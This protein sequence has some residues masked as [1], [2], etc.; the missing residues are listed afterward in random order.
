MALAAICQ[1]TSGPVWADNLATASDLVTQAAARGATFVALP[2]NFDL[3]ASAEAK[4]AFAEGTSASDRLFPL[5]DL[6]KRLRV[7]V[8]C[9][10]IAQK[11][12]GGKIHNTSVLLGPD[13][14]T[15]ATYRKVHLF[16]A[17]VGDGAPYRESELVAPGVETV[18]A[19]ADIGRIGM[20]IC[21]DL[22]FPE[23]Y[24]RLSTN[25]AEVL[26]VPSAFSEPTGRDHWEVLLRARAIE[27]FAYVIAP[28]QW[29]QHAGGR[30]TYGRSMIVDP[31]G[32]VMCCV[33]DGVGIG[34]AEIDLARLR[35][36]RA[37]LP[38]LTHRRL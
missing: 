11:A 3:M 27:N 33:P 28:A 6:A 18:V 36:I 24:R 26:C 22:R 35:A 1:M 10:S 2:E 21:Y 37:K 5:R 15:L 38:A 23:L 8:L 14:E 30:R 4:R 34:M 19:D 12:P 25:G 32:L 17:D 29:G 31:W 7:T 9:G 13:G 16:D 20:S